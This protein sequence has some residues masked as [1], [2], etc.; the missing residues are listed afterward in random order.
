MKLDFLS[1]V[2]ATP[3]RVESLSSQN[4]T[5]DQFQSWALLARDGIVSSVRSAWSYVNQHFTSSDRSERFLDPHSDCDLDQEDYD[6][7]CLF[8]RDCSSAED[9]RSKS[10]ASSAV[11][12]LS[13]EDLDKHHEGQCRPK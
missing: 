12:R 7:D 1:S 13:C 11:L 2:S 9:L 5:L 6:G 10:T 8:D 4:S 3:S